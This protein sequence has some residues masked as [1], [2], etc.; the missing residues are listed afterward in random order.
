M[1][2]CET[3][4]SVSPSFAYRMR[5]TYVVGHF[6]LSSPSLPISL[7]GLKAGPFP[8]RASLADRLGEAGFPSQLF[9]PGSVALVIKTGKF[10]QKI[11]SPKLFIGFEVWKEEYKRAKLAGYEV[12]KNLQCISKEI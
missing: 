7:W 12:R 4:R 10:V 6:H 8:H 1:P 11:G 2:A 3:T 5:L 9:N